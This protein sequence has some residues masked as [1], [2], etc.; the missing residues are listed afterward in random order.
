MLTITE[1]AYV[2]VNL[3]LDVLDK[4]PDGYHNIK[5][6]MQTVSLHDEVEICLG[7]GT[8]WSIRCTHNGVPTDRKN[9]AWRAAEAFFQE[10]GDDPN[11]LIISI[12]KHIPM[13]A[14]LGG[15][16][17]DAAAVLRGL[18]KAYSEPISV[19]R[20]AE[21]GGTIGSDIPFCVVGGAAMAEGRGELLRMLPG[22]PACDMIIC[23]PEF[24]AST[25]Q[26]YKK[27][28]EMTIECR[29]NQDA[30]EKALSRGDL[31]GIADHLC[32]V[33]EPVVAGEHKEIALIRRI[34]MECGAMGVCMSGS[35]SAVFAIFPN[36]D[37]A[38]KA[39]SMLVEAEIR[40]FLSHPV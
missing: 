29:P 27:L 35:G 3:T 21:L 28:D 13:E 30:M 33:F 19:R 9:L 31:K 17:A 38:R 6:I 7:T 25:P 1:P 16:S 12:E 23:K 8:P 39:K 5:S 4:R 26:L 20:L 36:G 18:N 22:M 37:C 24:S 34:C 40:T 11:G 10:I 15:G 32:N 2:K 14:G